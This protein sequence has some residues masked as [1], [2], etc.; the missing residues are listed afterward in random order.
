[1]TLKELKVDPRNHGRDIFAL[2]DCLNKGKIDLESIFKEIDQAYSVGKHRS[3]SYVK[4][5][6]K[7]IVRFLTK[8]P[9]LINRPT[10]TSTASPA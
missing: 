7:S 5:R 1:M 2:I 6:K 8:Y 9:E 3:P 10:E 4:G